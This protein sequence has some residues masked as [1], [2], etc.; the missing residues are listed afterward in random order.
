MHKQL[1]NTLDIILAIVRQLLEVA[2]AVALAV[3]AILNIKIY[4]N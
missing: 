4:L 1:Y 3:C 2:V